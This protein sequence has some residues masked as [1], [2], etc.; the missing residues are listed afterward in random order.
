MLSYSELKEFSTYFK[1]M[2]RNQ[3]V[4]PDAVKALFAGIDDILA[5]VKSRQGRP[6]NDLAVNQITA[7]LVKGVLAE[8]FK[9][10]PYSEITQF[11]IQKH[12][13]F[14]HNRDELSVP[15]DSKAQMRCLIKAGISLKKV[16][17]QP[18][19]LTDLE[20]LDL[21]QQR[22]D[23]FTIGNK[24]L[25][26]AA[27]NAF[28][29]VGKLRWQGFTLTKPDVQCLLDHGAS[30]DVFDAEEVRD[31][32]GVLLTDWRQVNSAQAAGISIAKADPSLLMI[33]TMGQ[34]QLAVQCQLSLVTMTIASALTI[35]PE[36]YQHCDYSQLT[37][38]QYQ[39][40]V[41]YNVDGKMPPAAHLPEPALKNK[42]I[43]DLSNNEVAMF[44]DWLNELQNSPRFDQQTHHFIHADREHL[45]QSARLQINDELVSQLLSE[46]LSQDGVNHCQH[47]R[48]LTGWIEDYRKGVLVSTPAET[49]FALVKQ[50]HQ[51][52]AVQFDTAES[53][54]YCQPIYQLFLA[55][56]WHLER[57]GFPG[58]EMRPEALAEIGVSAIQFS[59]VEFEKI[60]LL[61]SESGL[62]AYHLDDV[63]HVF[64][65]KRELM[66]PFTLKPFNDEQVAFLLLHCPGVM[67]QFCDYYEIQQDQLT[68]RPLLDEAVVKRVF[69]LR[70]ELRRNTDP[71]FSQNKADK[72]L[73]TF[74][75]FMS[76][77]PTDIEVLENLQYN[78]VRRGTIKF[79]QL[80]YGAAYG[81]C[82]EALNKDV[83]EWIEKFE[84]QYKDTTLQ[85]WLK[86]EN[87]NAIQG[88]MDNVLLRYSTIRHQM[89]KND[90]SSGLGQV[91]LFKF[92][93]AYHGSA[94]TVMKLSIARSK[95][96][97]LMP[98]QGGAR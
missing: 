17:I 78:T 25:L 68:L 15:V 21:I 28:G 77:Y 90:T 37:W 44:C 3:T 33:E 26:L 16:Q 92:Q 30:F 36:V 11:F 52:K 14:Q 65:L 49:L 51:K 84:S 47:L 22:Q 42:V 58:D 98:S 50:F 1:N 55:L 67:Q 13:C 96:G 46:Y 56:A 35:T 18:T 64:A 82:T 87:L 60:L 79:K 9:R 93:A 80:F 32:S 5:R 24:A 76:G 38:L 70:E 27:V 4:W 62:S 20:D 43:K 10:K 23:C 41:C 73:R 61:K 12:Q 45:I 88:E 71:V 86:Q 53:I 19:V 29:S 40:L 6:L 94:N 89:Q 66:D 81:G 75:D 31:L 63:L 69:Q 72:T 34:L 59:H 39:R 8:A 54:V 91:G 57:V 48:A 74:A 85:D 95:L 7:L 2:C 97:R 83:L